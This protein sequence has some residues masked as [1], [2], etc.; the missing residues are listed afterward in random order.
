M[1]KRCLPDPA[2]TFHNPEG[3]EWMLKTEFQNITKPR[4]MVFQLMGEFLGE[5]GIFV[6]THGNDFPVK[7]KLWEMQRKLGSKIFTKKNFQSKMHP[8]FVEK[9]R[10]VLKRV[11]SVAKN[12]E[13]IDM[14][15]IF[16]C[17]T[18]DSI[19]KFFFG[20]DVSSVDSNMS[21]YAV[22]FDTAHREMMKLIEEVLPIFSAA[23][24]LPFPLD[25]AVK[26]IAR[27]TSSHNVP[28]K[29]A[30][31]NLNDHIK[32]YV[33]KIKGDKSIDSRFDLISFFMKSYPKEHWDTEEFTTLIKQVVLNFTIAGRDTTACTLTWLFYELTQNKDVQDKLLEEIKA[34]KQGRGNDYVPSVSEL[35]AENLPYLNGAIYEAL[36]LH[37]AVPNEQ[38]TSLKDLWYPDPA[39]GKNIF[40]PKGTE[41]CFSPYAVGRTEK[42]FPNALKFDPTRWIDFK[43]K[44]KTMFEFPVFQ[45]GYRFCLGK[46]MAIFEAKLLTFMLIDKFHFDLKEGEKELTGEALMMTM[47]MENR[48][49]EGITHQLLLKPTL[50]V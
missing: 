16:F 36:R 8:T 35:S 14:Q 11:S 24:F 3:I 26:G 42:F 31:K 49:P 40:I 15:D 13:Y 48:R 37:P 5:N 30:V 38:K 22:Q 43:Q 10:K 27:A 12:G 32:E 47:A 4:D 25:Q 34:F 33:E 7:H 18:M 41:L 29:T 46:D 17:F 20:N 50:R 21:F 39:T 44:E 6:V 2:L 1:S 9:G 45:A 28:F 19:E 23:D